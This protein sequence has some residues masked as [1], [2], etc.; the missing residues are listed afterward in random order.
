[1]G[2]GLLLLAGSSNRS[3]AYPRYNDAGAGGGCSDCHGLFTGGTSPKGTVFP[4]NSKHEMHNGS[5]SMATEC[6]LCHSAGDTRNPYTYTS[7]GTANNTGRGCAGC[8]VGAGLRAHHVAK[9]VTLCYDCHLPEA[10][11]PENVKPPYYGTVDTK[12][13]HPENLVA[14]A[15]TNENW[16]VGDFMGLDNDGNT[17]YDAADFACSPYRILSVTKEGNNVRITW[18]TAGGRTDA[19]QASRNVVGTYSNVSSALPITGVG[20]VT[21]NYV[22]VGGATNAMRFYR[23]KFS[24]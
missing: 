2:A 10:S 22:E 14:A 20:V 17:L 13:D 21:T 6:N 8:H 1:M 18:Q 5:T 7:T 3:G 16:S 23:L 9:G 24:P 11:D 19:I 15:N 4:A 12:A